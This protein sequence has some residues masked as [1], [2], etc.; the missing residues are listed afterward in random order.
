MNDS[1]TATVKTDAAGN[2]YLDDPQAVAF[3]QAV[4]KHNCRNTFQI[5]RDRVEH[6]KAR[7]HALGKKASEVVIVLINV[8]APYG[9]PIAD[10]L[11]PGQD[12]QAIRG[13]GQVPFA[14]GLA[15]RDGMEDIVTEIDPELGARMKAKAADFVVVVIDHGVIQVFKADGTEI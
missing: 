4:A 8:D 5:Q 13:Q 15:S 12:W 7:I 2:L 1:P 6:F 10:L 9:K 14:R 3:V 11:M